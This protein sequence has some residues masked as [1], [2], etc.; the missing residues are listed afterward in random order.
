[1]HERSANFFV[2]VA[3][4]QSVITS[5]NHQVEQQYGLHL[6][7]V[8]LPGVT[9]QIQVQLLKIP[10]L[11]QK[12]NCIPELDTIWLYIPTEKFAVLQMRTICI[13][14]T[15]FTTWH[16]ERIVSIILAY[17]EVLSAGYPGHIKIRGILTNQYVAMNRRGRL[18]GEVSGNK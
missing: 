17:L 18:Y 14:G 16:C 7:Q 9:W 6:H 5:T 8:L 1:M 10:L 11:V 15:H 3:L 2:G 12:C 13:V 4:L